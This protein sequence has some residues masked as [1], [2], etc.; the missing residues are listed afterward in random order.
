MR[1]GLSD[2]RVLACIVVPNAKQSMKQLDVKLLVNFHDRA[3]IIIFSSKGFEIAV[4]RSL[5]TQDRGWT[6]E[7]EADVDLGIKSNCQRLQGFPTLNGFVSGDR[8]EACDRRFGSPS[9]RNLLYQQSEL[10]HLEQQLEAFDPEDTQDLGNVAA[11][12]RAREWEHFANEYDK[13]ARLHRELQ[14][15]IKCKLKEYRGY[16]RD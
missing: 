15:R 13:N 9:A 5:E 12:Q 10:H 11:Q 3:T 6:M 16:L 2:G 4:V 1:V 14:S 8:Q 7:E